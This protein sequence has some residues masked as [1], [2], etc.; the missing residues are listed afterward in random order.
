MDWKTKSIVFFSFVFKWKKLFRTVLGRNFGLFCAQVEAS[1]R[2]N[3]TVPDLCFSR[4]KIELEMKITFS[5]F[6]FAYHR[7]QH[8]Q[9]SRAIQNSRRWRFATL[10]TSMLAF[11]S[12]YFVLVKVLNVLEPIKVRFDC[13][14]KR[15]YVQWKNIEIK[16]FRSTNFVWAQPACKFSWKTDEANSLAFDQCR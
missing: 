3:Q 6:C 14:K 15:R 8:K 13:W 1:P 5:R 11:D 4:R 7:D 2:A 10:I 16:F 9:L 12:I